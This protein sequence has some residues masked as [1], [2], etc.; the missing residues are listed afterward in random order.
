M[1]GPTNALAALPWIQDAL[2]SGR[3]VPAHHFDKRCVERGVDILE[4][5][6]AT[7]RA[8]GCSPYPDGEP[9]QDGTCWRVTGKTMAGNELCIGFEAFEDEAGEQVVICTVFW[10]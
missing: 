2:G 3:Y 1:P 10:R 5:K 6:Y 4:V 9:T 7:A 8:T